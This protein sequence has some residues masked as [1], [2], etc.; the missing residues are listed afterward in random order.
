MTCY[1]LSKLNFVLLRIR[2]DSSKEELSISRLKELFWG[3]IIS[4]IARC[5][6]REEA[7]L[8]LDPNV[9]PG[10][11]LRFARRH[12]LRRANERTSFECGDCDLKFW[13]QPLLLQHQS[14]V[15]GKSK[16]EIVEESKISNVGEMNKESSDEEELKNDETGKDPDLSNLYELEQRVKE[17]EEEKVQDPTTA[18]QRRRNEKVDLRIRC[19]RAATAVLR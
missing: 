7:L 15:H 10:F 2:E 9:K 8:R 12:K 16:R 3:E 18:K 1:S 11:V 14:D 5:P 4:I 6:E 19:E 13:Y 17:L